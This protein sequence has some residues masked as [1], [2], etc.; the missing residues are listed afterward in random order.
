[1]TPGPH[2]L[3]AELPRSSPDRAVQRECARALYNAAY[4]AMLR[5]NDRARALHDEAEEAA[6]RTGYQVV[7]QGCAVIRLRLD[8]AEGQWAGL[9]DRLA[10]VLPQ[11]A[12][13]TKFRIA[14]LMVRA[15]LEVARGSW[16]AAR[17]HLATFTTTD[18]ENA[19]WDVGQAGVTL[20]GRID[21]LEGDPEAAWERLRRPLAARRRQ[22]RLG[23]GPRP[24]ADR[25]AGGPGLRAAAW[26]PSG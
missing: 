10:A 14:A 9:D 17:Q 18:E 20:L 21:L 7:E 8:L 2:E 15:A 3:L 4:G 12:E 5:G 25:R 22:G 23:P 26:R 24:D 11:T 19:S 6:R 13:G 16:A 1:M